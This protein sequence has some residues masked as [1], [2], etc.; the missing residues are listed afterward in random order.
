MKPIGRLLAGIDDTR[1]QLLQFLV[2]LFPVVSEF[3]K[4]GR[5]CLGKRGLQ[6]GIIV[7][8]N[9]EVVTNSVLH[10]GRLRLGAV[11]CANLFL[12][13]R[14]EN[15]DGL[16]LYLNPFRLKICIGNAAQ[17]GR[18]ALHAQAL[19]PEV[20]S[21]QHVDLGKGLIVGHIVKGLPW[22][23]KTRFRHLVSFLKASMKSKRRSS[24]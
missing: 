21:R 22:P 20:L 13:I 4:Y 24:S 17:L 14:I 7:Q 10:L 23:G 18:D 6:V 8:F 3:F 1:P 12:K 16:D 5:Q 2:D 11:P 15:R 9:I 19:I